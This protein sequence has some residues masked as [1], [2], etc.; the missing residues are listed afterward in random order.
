MARR[1]TVATKPKKKVVRLTRRVNGYALMPVD[2]WDKAK[3]FVRERGMFM[4]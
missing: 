4:L 1:T 2:N 3:H